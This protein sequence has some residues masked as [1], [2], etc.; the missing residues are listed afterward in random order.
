MFVP[1]SGLY[2]KKPH[3]FCNSLEH[4]L[5]FRLKMLTACVHQSRFWNFEAPFVMTGINSTIENND[6]QVQFLSPSVHFRYL[7]NEIWTAG[8]RLLTMFV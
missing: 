6:S 8:I 5:S 1:L 4:L 2:N 3:F 7:D